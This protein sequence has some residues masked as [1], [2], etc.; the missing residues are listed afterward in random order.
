MSDIYYRDRANLYKPKTSSEIAAA[1]K[2]L[3]AQ[4]FGDHTISH[5]LKI[6]VN[7]VRMIVGGTRSA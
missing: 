4:K 2:D 7:L 1:A 6:D 3:A 5:I